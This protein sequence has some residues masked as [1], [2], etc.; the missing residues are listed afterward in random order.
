MLFSAATI[1][2][3]AAGFAS[4][5]PTVQKRASEINDGVILNYALTLEHLEDTFYRE[6]LSK[7]SEKDFA[8]AG[9]DSTFYNNIKKV[10]SDETSHVDFLTKGLKAAGA[11]PVAACTYD[12]GYTDVKSFLAT[13]SVLEGVGVSAYLGAA[14][15]IMSKTYLTAAGSILTVEARHSSYIRGHLKEVPFPQA[16]DAPLTYNEV[17]SLAS[18]FITSCPKDNPALPVKAF[19]KLALDP[20]TEMPVKTGD[21]VTLQTPGYAVKG[22]DGQKVYAAF[23][24]VTGPTFVEAKAVDGGFSV[25]IP[26]GFAGQTYVV[27]T[28]CKDAVSDDTVAAG[29]AIIEISS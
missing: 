21:M 1:A 10:S 27:L 3:A 25:E 23:I 12:F 7:F 4:A 28:G 29:P 11:T 20:S 6:A 5:A 17:Y 9:Y 18:G 14:A 2:L 24:A 22:A 13:A 26:E 19:P 8:D 16:F 15:D